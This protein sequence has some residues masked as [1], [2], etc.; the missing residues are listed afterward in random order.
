MSDSEDITLIFRDGSKQVWPKK[1]IRQFKIIS[2]VIE[3]FPD[4]EPIPVSSA[5]N[6]ELF[7]RI[8]DKEC[9]LSTEGELRAYLTQSVPLPPKPQLKVHQTNVG[10]GIDP[11]RAQVDELQ[12][13]SNLVYLHL[14]PYI[15]HT[16]DT[17][18]RTDPCLCET[19]MKH[20]TISAGDPLK[21]PTRGY[22]RNTIIYPKPDG[23][24]GKQWIAWLNQFPPKSTIS[25]EHAGPLCFEVTQIYQD[26]DSDGKEQ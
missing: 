9:G 3:Q 8:M 19:L 12:L 22:L 20:T 15:P 7:A 2:D 21:K 5:I 10:S 18:V 24:I 17:H 26:S 6:P 23:S 1:A 13:C 14:R 16:S 11:I 25:I 4:N